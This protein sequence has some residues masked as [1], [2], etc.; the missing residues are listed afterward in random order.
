MIANHVGANYPDKFGRYALGECVGVSVGATGNAVATIPILGGTQYVIRQITVWNAN[1]TIA[2]ANVTI[3]TSNDGNASNAVSNN[4]V[5]SNVSSTT[6]YQDLGLASGTLTT[7]YSASSL[8][9]KVNT[10]V[11]NGTCDITVFGDVV[12]L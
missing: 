6:T 11:T 1:A 8:F 12:A 5:L 4:V 10:A 3:L 9:V 2:T 7:V